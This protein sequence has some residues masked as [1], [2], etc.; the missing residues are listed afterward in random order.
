MNYEIGCRF[1]EYPRRITGSSAYDAEFMATVPS[2]SHRHDPQRSYS[3]P[4]AC[5][6]YEAAE[7]A[8]RRYLGLISHWFPR[9]FVRTGPG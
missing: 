7:V 4:P 6:S 3:E 5:P 2:F 8:S 9:C 1:I